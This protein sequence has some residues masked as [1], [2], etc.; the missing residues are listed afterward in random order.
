METRNEST[1]DRNQPSTLASEVTA[2]DSPTRHSQKKSGAGSN[3]GA[4]PPL[5]ARFLRWLYPDQRKTNRHAMPPLIAYLGSIRTSKVFKVG[6]VS[7]SGFYM[8]TQERWLPGS[9][10]PVTLQRTDG[11][12]LLATITLLSTVVRSGIDG[13]GFSF[14][15]VGTTAAESADPR[16]GI[17][18]LEGDLKL[19]LD[20]L[21]FT[22][23]EPEFERAS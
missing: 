19:F 11:V 10:M 1:N 2:I 6:D 15:L 3:P 14:A 7:S 18:G 21:H 20:G 9:E 22:E 5:F 23:Y 17:W 4:R 8:L 12:D 16:P 13:V